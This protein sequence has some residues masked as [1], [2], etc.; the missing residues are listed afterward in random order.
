[1]VILYNSLLE[2]FHYWELVIDHDGCSDTI[3]ISV[4]SL[5]CYTTEI[6]TKYS[7]CLLIGS[8]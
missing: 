4:W 6:E 5:S 8:K 3:F 7:V 1:M 2:I